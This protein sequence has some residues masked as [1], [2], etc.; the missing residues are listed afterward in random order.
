M[1]ECCAI[2]PGLFELRESENALLDFDFT[3]LLPTGVTLSATPVSVTPTLV[4]GSGALT[5][6]TITVSSPKVQV[7]V[8][9]GSA[10][11]GSLFR[12][13]ATARTSAGADL[14]MYGFV[15]YVA[16]PSEPAADC[17]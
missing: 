15:R 2:E 13:R 17:G 10:A 14:T 6:G 4:D 16:P 9:P 1:S 11:Q 8:A 5:I 3:N 7:F 12:L